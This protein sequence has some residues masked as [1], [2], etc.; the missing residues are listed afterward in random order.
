M[1]GSKYLQKHVVDEY[2]AELNLFDESS[3]IKEIIWIA[4]FIA[5]MFI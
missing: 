5:K 2:E 4:P 1:T 3:G